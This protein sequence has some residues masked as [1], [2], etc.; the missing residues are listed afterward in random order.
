[1]KNFTLLGI[2]ITKEVFHLHGVDAHGKV[3]LQKKL[4]RA[5]LYEFIVKIPRCTIVM[6]ACGGANYLARKFMGYGHSVRLIS[7]QFVKPFVKTNKND[8]ND[9]EAIT[10]AASRKSMRYVTPKT[11]EQQASQTLLKMRDGFV[12]S[13]TELVNRLRGF[14]LEFGVTIP[15]G[16]DNSKKAIPLV[17]EDAEN[18]LPPLLRE[19]VSE[20]YEEV[21]ALD[22]K[23]KLYDK[24]IALRVKSNDACQRLK[25]I[26]GVGD[27]SATCF[28]SIL[29]E[30]QSFKNGRHFAAYLGLVPKQNSTGG[31]H[32][33]LGISKR[34]NTYM[35][36]IL[37]HGARAAMRWAKTKDD[38]LSLGPKG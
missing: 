28:A 26:P 21:K 31:K 32:Q 16:I 18:E 36:T 11:A 10:E 38:K 5:K 22:E 9:A 35:R 6:E 33:L 34:G 29:G 23:V 2:D 3:L 17:L 37:I 12:R 24:K 8:K 15:K 13:R 4:T 19:L 27:I 14:L 20:G 25:A 30:Y 7:P 1:M